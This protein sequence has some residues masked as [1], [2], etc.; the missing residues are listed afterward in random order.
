MPAKV[1]SGSM[2]PMAAES[3]LSHPTSDAHEALP[4]TTAVDHAGWESWLHQLVQ[5]KIEHGHCFVPLRCREHPRLGAWLAEQSELFHKG[6][7]DSEQQRALEALGFEWDFHADERSARRSADRRWEEQFAQ[8]LAFKAEHGHCEVPTRWKRNPSLANWV[9][10]LRCANCHNRVPPE[11]KERLDQAGF[12]WRSSKPHFNAGWEARFAEL[13]AF[14]QQHGHLRVTLKSEISPGLMHWRDNQRIN[15]HNGT[16]TPVRKARLD[17]IGFEWV[18][19]TRPPVSKEVYN[20]ERWEAMFAQ[21]AA[22]QAEHG[23]CQ[24]PPSYPACPGLGKWV[25]R[26]RRKRKG[27][28]KDEAA[29]LPE[30]IA[31]LEALGFVWK[32][33]QQPNAV[34]WER[35]FA[36]LV[37]FQQR[38]GHLRVTLKSE[39]SPGLMNWRDNQRVNLRKGTLSPARKARLDAIGFEWVCPARPPVSKE[40]YNEQIWETRFTQLCAFKQAHGHC[41]VPAAWAANPDLGK[42]VMRQRLKHKGAYKDEPPLRPD[43]AARLEA[44]GFVWKSAKLHYSKGWEGRLAELVAFKEQYGHL[45]VTKTNQTSPGLMHWRDNQRI[46]LQ[47]GVMPPE[48]KARLDALG[49]EWPSPGHRVR[50]KT[51]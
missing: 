9:I 6:R 7:L 45:H 14:Q 40:E 24:V 31:R 32:A 18:C 16:L 35:R 17:A 50:R 27:P 2:L 1:H 36:E 21:L 28:L 23:H 48:Q 25:I 44:I 20:E 8:L 46:R 22:Y 12:L 38:H 13:V 41:Q 3:Q 30:R 51:G 19:P 26:Q 42:W 10:N 29:L 43:R 15:L 39:T 49:F 33:S 34:G 4:Q 5:Y 37:A 47:Q 11:R